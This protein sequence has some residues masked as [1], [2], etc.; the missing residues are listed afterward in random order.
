[1]VSFVPRLLYSRGNKPIGQGAGWA[2][3]L[4]LPGIEPRFL[5]CSAKSLYRLRSA[6]IINT[7]LTKELKCGPN[8][9]L[10]QPILLLLLP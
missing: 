2:A 9:L 7:P 6:V 1:M 8:G 3:L 5:G 10:I 4:P